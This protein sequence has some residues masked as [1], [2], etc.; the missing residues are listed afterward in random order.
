MLEH[1]SVARSRETRGA[2]LAFTLGAIIGV[3]GGIIGLGG[4]EFRLPLLI[5]L[6]GFPALEAVILNKA[7]SLIV[8]AS[9]LPF[10]AATVP[11]SVL[12]DRWTIIANL[13]GGSILGAWLAADWVTRM[14]SEMLYKVISVLLAAMAVVLLLGHG[15]AYGGAQSVSGINLVAAGLA[16][17]F[18]IGMVAA[19]MGVAGGELL[20]PTLILLFGEDIKLAGSLSLAI[21]LPTMLTGFARYS[22]ASSFSVLGRHWRFAV[23][24]ATGSIIGAFI[25]ARL[26]GLVP[27]SVLVP[28][29]AILLL[30]SAVKVWQHG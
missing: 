29:L 26:L 24:M 2:F 23:A 3:L 7:M 1:E 17:G 10:R 6:F 12:L 9:A 14:R 8:V 4:A 25:G 5:G 15:A 13:L 30:V 28:L 21:G 11:F 20:I 16:A 18:I 22:R 27:S 19:F